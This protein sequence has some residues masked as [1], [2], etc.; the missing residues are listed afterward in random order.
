LYEERLRSTELKR[1]ELEDKVTDLEAKL[2]VQVARSPQPNNSTPTMVQIENE[3]LQDQVVHLQK[4]VSTLED[5]LEDSRASAEKEETLIRD[6]MRRVK[7][8]EDAMKK[9]IGD[10]RKE[11]ERVLKAEAAA[12]NRVEEI[13]EALRESTI[14]LENAQAEIEGLRADLDVSVHLPLRS[15]YLMFS[16]H[17][18][19][20]VASSSASEQL[21]SFESQNLQV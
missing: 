19:G 1:Y 2:S 10:S 6:R 18:N 3:G 8:K 9:E 13:E 15:S 14:A 11:V 20:L 12:R 4:K 5:M 17:A 7:E 21:K 16:Q